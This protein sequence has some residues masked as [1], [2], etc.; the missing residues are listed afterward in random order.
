MSEEQKNYGQILKSSS[1]MG[2]SQVVSILVG[3]VRVKLVAVLLGPVGIGLLGVFRSIEE[4][5]V[6]ISGL[7]INSSGVR[8]VAEAAG[9]SD[10]LR[11]ARVGLTLRRICWM[12]GILGA[13]LLAALAKP[14]SRLTFGSPDYSKHVACLGLV[15][16][17]TSIAGG[18]MT[19][20]HGMRRIGDLAR[21]NII[22]SIFGTITAAGFYYWLGL[23][24][25]IPALISISAFGLAISYWYSR[26]VKTLKV[27]MSWLETLLSAR[28]MLTLGLVFL[29]AGLLHSVCG[30]V[31]RILI[32]NEIDLAAVGIFFAAYNLSLM[33]VDMITRAMGADF[34]PKLTS[35][36]GDHGE[37]RTLVNQQCQMGLILA[38]PGL[39]G[40]IVLAPWVIEIFYSDAFLEAAELMRWCLVGC[41]CRV[42]SWPLSYVI[43]AKNR[44]K[45]QAVV[46]CSHQ[47]F[48]ILLIFVG[49]KF[50]GLKGLALAELAN[51]LVHIFTTS[52][53]ARRLID[54]TWSRSSK[55]I[56]VKCFVIIIALFAVCTQLPIVWSLVIGISMTFLVS[57]WCLRSLCVRLEDE[58]FV[59]EW[60]KKIPLINCFM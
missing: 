35:V 37:M 9:T 2:G 40:L 41:I 57:M 11:I 36:A 26:R 21:I 25:I 49:L 28:A 10:K 13:F 48:R 8:D 58:H 55:A 1:I 30:Y 22:S 4:M 46:E 15:V 53:C 56:I 39:A 52:F 42:V 23:E 19:L 47:A 31:T 59:V 18:Q 17:M 45:F 54:F 7:G 16:L 32:I 38:L 20:V 43:I 24:G 29:M 3:M 14:L 5:A 12:S 60:A 27:R 44:P 51:S 50:F 6:T 33:F 34:Y